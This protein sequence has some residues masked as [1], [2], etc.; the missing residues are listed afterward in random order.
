MFRL[1]DA[2]RRYRAQHRSPAELRCVAATATTLSPPANPDAAGLVASVAAVA[3]PTSESTDLA[4]LIEQ[5]QE[6]GA[7][8]QHSQNAL[9][10]RPAHWGQLDTIAPHWKAL[11]LRLQTNDQGED[12]GAGRSA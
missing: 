11:L 6:E 1:N 2:V 9:L 7:L 4:R 10:I 3:A 5:L 12:N 8:L